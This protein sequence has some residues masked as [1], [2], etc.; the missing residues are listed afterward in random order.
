[1]F[2]VSVD[3]ALEDIMTLASPSQ[4]DKSKLKLTQ[5]GLE[6]ISF[7]GSHRQTDYVPD[8]PH[9]LANSPLHLQRSYK[10]SVCPDQS[11]TNKLEQNFL[12]TINSVQITSDANIGSGQ[13]IKSS[14]F[15]EQYKFV[16]SIPIPYN[17]AVMLIKDGVKLMV[18]LRGPPGSG[19]SHLARTLLIDAGIN[20]SEHKKHIFCTDNY[21]VRRNIYNFVPEL[22]HQAHTWNQRNVASAVRDQI[23][24]V[25][26]DNTNTEVWEMKVYADLAVSAG[27]HIEIL[28][29]NTWWIFNDRELARRSVHNVPK[30]KIRIMVDRYEKDITAEVMLNKCKLRYSLSNV[31]PQSVPKSKWKDKLSGQTNIK[32][33]KKKKTVLTNNCQSD[34]STGDLMS[35]P[36]DPRECGQSTKLPLPDEQSKH[37]LPR[38]KNGDTFSYT[39]IDE[40]DTRKVISSGSI[41]KH[42]LNSFVQSESN[43]IVSLPSTN[44]FLPGVNSAKND[45]ALLEGS[46]PD[47]FK[48]ADDKSSGNNT[49][50]CMAEFKKFVAALAHSETPRN[51]LEPTLK[52]ATIL[53][54]ESPQ[55]SISNNIPLVPTFVD[56]NQNNDIYDLEDNKSKNDSNSFTTKIIDSVQSISVVKDNTTKH[57]EK[58]TQRLNVGNSVMW[59]Y[60]LVNDDG[61]FTYKRNDYNPI[62]LKAGK[63]GE[64][65]QPVTT[66]TSNDGNTVVQVIPVVED[67]ITKHIGKQTQCLNT[68]K[69]DMWKYVLLYD[70]G[71]SNKGEK[72]HQEIRNA[73][74]DKGNPSSVNKTHNLQNSDMYTHKNVLGDLNSTC[75]HPG[76]DQI[77]VFS[78]NKLEIDCPSPLNCDIYFGENKFNVGDGNDC[79]TP[80]SNINNN[81]AANGDLEGNVTLSLENSCDGIKMCKDDKFESKKEITTN[82]LDKNTDC[83]ADNFEN[84]IGIINEETNFIVNYDKLSEDIHD[85]KDFEGQHSL[86]CEEKDLFDSGEPF[87]KH[88]EDFNKDV[89]KRAAAAYTI[90]FSNEVNL[91]VAE[92]EGGVDTLELINSYKSNPNNVSNCLPERLFN[93]IQTTESDHLKDNCKPTESCGTKEMVNGE[94]HSD[95][96]FMMETILKSMSPLCENS[97]VAPPTKI[98]NSSQI[99]SRPN[100]YGESSEPKEE[101]TLIE[102]HS[103]SKPPHNIS[104]SNPKTLVFSPFQS[105]TKEMHSEFQSWDSVPNHFEDWNGLKNLSSTAKD[106]AAAALPQRARIKSKKLISSATNTNYEDFLNLKHDN[107]LGLKTLEGHC[108]NITESI[109]DIKQELS[110]TLFL[111]K[112]TMTTFRC[113]DSVDKYDIAIISNLF[114]KIPQKYIFDMI[115]RCHGDVNWAVDLLL[116]SE[117]S[118]YENTEVNDTVCN[119][120]SPKSEQVSVSNHI[121]QEI[122]DNNENVSFNKSDDTATVVLM[123]EQAKVKKMIENCIVISK[124]H[125]S[126]KMLK[127]LKRRNPKYASLVENSQPQLDKSDDKGPDNNEVLSSDNVGTKDYGSD[128]ANSCSDSYDTEDDVGF[129]VVINNDLILQLHQTFGNSNM[130]ELGGM[131]LLT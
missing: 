55:P 90:D 39:G 36:P 29:P 101:H 79:M 74:S 102:G 9:N 69:S 71:K 25:I 20:L 5:S 8:V 32:S 121:I 100:S 17:R 24:P 118:I 112:S 70:N 60:V 26:V 124:S 110:Q 51:E 98:I 57:I 66:V 80:N 109:Y 27:Y 75:V 72:S 128:E 65:Y 129:E 63:H 86:N 130:P 84:N 10:K 116:D 104:R 68:D 42:S 38:Q 35:F 59:E 64:S 61:T 12:K 41:S 14:Q 48:R 99:E 44:P 15:L 108:R 87:F 40:L 30:A 18:I 120:T 97:T 52:E 7:S 62:P 95:V 105:E 89:N 77:Q 81:N 67:T 13:Q 93:E 23:S 76:S 119:I 49:S 117:H 22:L 1:M 6:N 3:A 82:K 43:L 21:F 53:N 2:D 94:T 11:N 103:G 46:S 91:R 83:L 45:K 123:Q 47:E 127:M 115:D 113:L 31:P 85:E 37:S 126:D 114:P 92:S 107:L 96:L 78:N 122:V 16:K 34:R 28:E 111:D 58:K 106:E 50:D 131:Y 54:T 88:S 19:K 4:A 125:Y 33:K 56:V 73:T